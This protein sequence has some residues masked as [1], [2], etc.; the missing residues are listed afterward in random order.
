MPQV[1]ARLNVCHDSEPNSTAVSHLHKRQRK[2]SGAFKVCEGGRLTLSRNSV[3]GT[4]WHIGSNNT[5][6]SLDYKTEK[7]YTAFEDEPE[8]AG[9]EQHPTMDLLHI[10]SVRAS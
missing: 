8:R 6:V 4:I 9:N 10:L 1:K 2:H 3:M 5:D 7:T